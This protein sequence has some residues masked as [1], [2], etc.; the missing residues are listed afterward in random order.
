MSPRKE[1][2]VKIPVESVEEVDAPETEEETVAPEVVEEVV[3][4]EAEAP[5]MTEE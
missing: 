3:D 1:K 5:A 2:D 4:A